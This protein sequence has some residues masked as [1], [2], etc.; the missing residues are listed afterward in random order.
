[1]NEN[2]GHASIICCPSGGQLE[3]KRLLERPR[4]RWEDKIKMD[5][6][7]ISLSIGASGVLF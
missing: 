4:H 7:V 6:T 1:M 3:G 2:T 5:I